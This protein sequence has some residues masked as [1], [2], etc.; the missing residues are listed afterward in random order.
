[1]TDMSAARPFLRWAGSKRSVVKK[2]AANV[3]LDFNKY[4][5]PFVGSG[6][7]FFH[8][9]PKSAVLSDLNWEVVNL[10]EQVKGSPRELHKRLLAPGRDRETYLRIRQDFGSELEEIDRAASMLYLNRNCFNG[11]YRTNKSG[12][13][14]VPYAPQRRGEYPSEEELL[15][16]SKRLQD[17]E[18][19]GGDFFDVVFGRVGKGDFVY[20]DPPY[21]KSKGRIFNEYVKGHFNHEDTERLAILLRKID[22][23]GAFFLLS[24]I[25]DE[26]ISA[27]AKEW[28]YEKYYVQKNISGFV[29]S[30][31]K[32]PEYLIKN[33]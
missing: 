25:E 10:F 11:L 18:I 6:A 17:V 30:R 12:K 4:F 21:V 23:V 2:L 22:E 32:S 14:N 8:L 3:P 29:G 9:N 26:V 33:W 19:I 15:N 5:E 28:G 1:M 31:R 24:F 20:L 27:I 7:L 16:C 13:F